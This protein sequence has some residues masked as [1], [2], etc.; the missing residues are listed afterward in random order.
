MQTVT[1]ANGVQLTWDDTLTVGELIT[2]YNSGYFVLHRIELR[3]GSTPLM[4][5]TKVAQPD[6][7]LVNGRAEQCCDAS[8]VR[9]MSRVRIEAEW[10]DALEAAHKK[11]DNLLQFVQ[12]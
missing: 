10:S 2:T 7:S 6:G 4:Y 12:G 3:E 11:R 5:Y 9:R 8:Y 1:C